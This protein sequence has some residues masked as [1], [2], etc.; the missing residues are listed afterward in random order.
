MT[1]RKFLQSDQTCQ[2][3]TVG[4][5]QTRFTPEGLLELRVKD[6]RFTG[7]AGQGREKDGDFGAAVN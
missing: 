3:I 2:W 4:K 6:A 7:A 1:M 5:P